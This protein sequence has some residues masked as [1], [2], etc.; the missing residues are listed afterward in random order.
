LSVMTRRGVRSA[1]HDGLLEE[2]ARGNHVACRRHVC[3]ELSANS[4][5]DR[6]MQAP[7][8]ISQHRL[9]PGRRHLPIQTPAGAR[10]RLAHLRKMCCGSVK[11]GASTRLCSDRRPWH[12]NYRA[13]ASWPDSRCIT[14]RDTRHVAARR[15][16]EQPSCPAER[17]RVGQHRTRPHVPPRWLVAVPGVLHR[18][19]RYSRTASA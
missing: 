10:L 14:C 12:Y 7:P 13:I 8:N 16:F 6:C 18:T 3:I 4:S 19:G 17:R 5:S 15:F 9:T 11:T 2:P 1:G